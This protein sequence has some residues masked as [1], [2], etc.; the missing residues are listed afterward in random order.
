MCFLHEHC[1]SVKVHGKPHAEKYYP[2]ITGFHSPQPG[3]LNLLR[4]GCAALGQALAMGT[5]G[6]D[7]ASRK[8]S[9]CFLSLKQVGNGGALTLDC[10]SE[11]PFS[12]TPHFCLITGSSSWHPPFLMWL[13]VTA[14]CSWNVYLRSVH[15]CHVRWTSF[16]LLP[17][18][19]SQAL[20]MQG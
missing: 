18:H 4:G 7:R 10:P 11:V 3:P 20:S 17:Q 2:V 1:M 14:S 16:F 12:Q 9:L 15:D 19:C 6:T 5:A 8:F 13:S